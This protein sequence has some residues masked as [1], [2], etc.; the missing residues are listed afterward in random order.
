[1]WPCNLSDF[2]KYAEWDSAPT[3]TF[4]NFQSLTLCRLWLFQICRVRLCAL[5]YFSKYSDCYS[6]PS[7]TKFSQFDSAVSLTLLN[8]LLWLCVLSD[9]S[10][11][12]SVTLGI[13]QICRVGL[14]ALSDFSKYAEWVSAPS[15]TFPNMHSVTLSTLWLFQICRVWLCAISYFSKYA[16]CYSGPSSTKFW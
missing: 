5:S 10:N 12:Q 1:M 2:S 16:E 4:P 3:L 6:A 8:C 9:F 15:L 14:C 11:M 13:F 7:S